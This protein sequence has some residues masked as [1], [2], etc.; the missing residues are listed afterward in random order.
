MKSIT[1]KNTK[2]IRDFNFKFPEKKAV[3]LL[4]GSN[5]TGKTTLLTCMDRI[6]NSYAFARGFS[7]PKNIMGFDEYQSASIRYDVDDTCVIFR[8]RRSKWASTPRKNNAQLLST[9]GFTGSIFIKADSK[10]IDATAE[11][12]ERGTVQSANSV[13]VQTLNRIFETNKYTNLKKLKVTHGRGRTPSYFNIIKDGRKYYT[14]KRFSTGEIAILRL[15]EKIDAAENGALVLLD[16]AEMALHPRVQVNLLEYL[17]EKADEKD[18]MVFIS[19]HSPTMI[20]AT[21]PNE[22]ILLESDTDGNVSAVT[23]CYPAR[24]LGRIDYEDS[25]IFDYIFFV[26][27]EMARLFLKRLVAR[28]LLLAQQHSSALISIVPVGGF[29]ETARLAVLTK[30]QLFGKSKVFAFV[31][32]DAFEDLEHKPRFSELL[33]N[34]S[35]NFYI[36]D[37]SVT[38]EV[39]FIQALSGD[40]ENLR[41]NFRTHFHSEINSILRSAEYQACNANSVRKKSKLQFDVFVNKCMGTYGDDENTVKTTLINLLVDSLDD[42]DVYRVLNPVF[43]SR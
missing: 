34:T 25:N 2:G 17:K 42:S 20:K 4:V 12:I 1:I 43:N 24:A 37:L 35:N 22:V 23:P 15:I 30:N 10:R 3:Y 11:E 33:H 8:K 41:N 9:Y 27:D 21:K 31:D 14:E 32:S 38:P 40:D 16:E 28:Y 26:E 39:F 18:L 7:Q 6:C 29:Y 13:I 5:G 19:T 36:R